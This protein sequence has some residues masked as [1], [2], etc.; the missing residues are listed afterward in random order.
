MKQTVYVGKNATG[1]SMPE[2]WELLPCRLPPD[3]GPSDLSIRRMTENAL[4]SP[5]ADPDWGSVLTSGSKVT[6]ITD[7][8]ARP[9]PSREMLPALLDTLLEKGLRKESV[10]IVVGLGTHKP[11]E[12]AVLQEKIGE[13]ILRAFRVTQHDCQAEDLVPVERLKTGGEVRLNPTVANADIRIGLGS[14][15][16]HP[17]NGFGGG[18]KIIF[19]GVANYPAIREHHLAQT[20]HSKSIFGNLEGNPFYEEILRIA[21]KARLDFSLNCVFD[22]FDRVGAV[23]FGPF[24]QVHEE[25]TALGREL[26]GIHLTRPS[27]VTIISAY[28]YMEPFQVIKP[29]ITASLVTRP[30][31]TIILVAE[32]TGEMPGSFVDICERITDLSGKDVGKYAISKFRSNHLLLEKAPID[33]NCALFFTL[34]C[35]ENHRVAVVSRQL[36]HGNLQ[37]MGC[38]P[39][40]DLE[41]ALETE[42]RVLHHASVHLIPL[43]GMLPILP[44]GLNMGFETFTAET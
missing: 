40:L 1:F 43:G 32:T 13:D 42:S 29:L 20:V 6:I 41:T 8:I 19:P 38:I 24:E 3:K 2:G 21:R 4:S 39:Y 34:L 12:E 14:I 15:M 23:L 35:K 7:D 5:P 9:T 33:F 22:C 31:G 18:P 28:P 36:G 16:P 27:D 37:R 44:G 26:C 10:D 30:G 11:M 17:M 25:G